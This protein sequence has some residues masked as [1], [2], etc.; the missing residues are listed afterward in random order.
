MP[1]NGTALPF[2][3]G[4]G[5]QQ[6]DCPTVSMAYASS[7]RRAD[8]VGCVTVTG[9]APRPTIPPAPLG[10]P[11]NTFDIRGR[12]RQKLR[13]SV[14]T[15]GRGASPV[16]MPRIVDTPPCKAGAKGGQGRRTDVGLHQGT[17][18][19]PERKYAAQHAAQ[20]CQQNNKSLNLQ[21]DNHHHLS[22]RHKSVIRYESGIYPPPRN[23]CPLLS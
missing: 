19:C 22:R 17:A 13:R 9:L 10:L 5:W 4:S 15:V 11:C 7:P 23:P 1:P 18:D 3:G 2:F 20:A 16:A 8:Y 6:G 14:K 12:I 21:Q